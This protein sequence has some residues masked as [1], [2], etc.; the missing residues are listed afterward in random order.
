MICS[1]CGRSCHVNLYNTWTRKG[2]L[3]RTDWTP[4]DLAGRDIT[5]GYC[6]SCGSDNNSSSVFKWTKIGNV[7]PRAQLWQQST[8]KDVAHR[9]G[10]D[11]CADK[12][13]PAFGCDC[14][15][16]KE[17]FYQTGLSH[18]RSKDSMYSSLSHTWSKQSPYNI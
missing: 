9:V 17:N 13:N 18:S 10:T 4:Y 8:I 15:Q 7:T 16:V 2:S 3:S 5:E 1:T 11:K 6:P 12:Y 14:S